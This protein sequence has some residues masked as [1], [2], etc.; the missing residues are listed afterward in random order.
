MLHSCSVHLYMAYPFA[1]FLIQPVSFWSS[2]L[3]SGQNI[4]FTACRWSKNTCS[5]T[6]VPLEWRK[7]EFIFSF[8]YFHSSLVYL[9]VLVDFLTA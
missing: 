4:C 8:P 9:L 5:G 3:A 7:N 2:D 1:S 6:H